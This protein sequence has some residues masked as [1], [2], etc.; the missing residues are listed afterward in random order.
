M[1]NDSLILRG[2][3]Y[4]FIFETSILNIRI[5]AAGI[6]YSECI[7]NCRQYPFSTLPLQNDFALIKDF[8]VPKVISQDRYEPLAFHADISFDFT[9]MDFRFQ[10]YLH[11]RTAYTT[12]CPL[13]ANYRS[14][15]SVILIRYESK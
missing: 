13:L 7:K 14:L 1:K 8:L 4:N 15:W 9:K 6:N 12:D 2:F 3:F 5:P 10:P 11:G